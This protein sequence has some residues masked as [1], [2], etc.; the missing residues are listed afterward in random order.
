MSSLVAEVVTE[1]DYGSLPENS[2]IVVQQKWSEIESLLRVR[3]QNA[4]EIGYRLAEIKTELGHGRWLEWCESVFPYSH[5]TATRWMKLAET[6]GQITQIA[7]FGLSA[8]YALS[9]SDEEMMSAIAPGTPHKQ[10]KQQLEFAPGTEYVVNEPTSPFHGQTVR[11]NRRDGDVVFCDTA[12]GETQPLMFGWLGVDSNP[13]PE[14]TA[15]PKTSLSVML[16][17]TNL[18]LDIARER[19]RKLQQWGEKVCQRYQLDV[20]LHNEAIELGLI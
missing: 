6:H 9:G 11:V 4:I 3:T 20:D 10:V 13:K 14:K 17:D 12:G 5:D 7:E 2:R 1:F 15:N 16:E 8:A 18:A 19:S